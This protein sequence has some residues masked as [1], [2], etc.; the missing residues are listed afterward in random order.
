MPATLGPEYLLRLLD[1]KA[2]GVNLLPAA[3]GQQDPGV[4]HDGW[5][6][7]LP[8]LKQQH[9]NTLAQLNGCCIFRNVYDC[10]QSL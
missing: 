5:S 6:S 2:V 8:T 9:E 1:D 7:I 3:A 10:V 4:A